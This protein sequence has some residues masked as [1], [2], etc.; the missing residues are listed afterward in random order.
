MYRETKA[1][2]AKINAAKNVAKKEYDK[3]AEQYKKDLAKV[4]ALSGSA[5]EKQT[6]KVR[7]MERTINEWRTAR[8]KE[9]QTEALKLRGEIVAE[10]TSAIND[11]MI[12]EPMA[13]V[14]DTGGM[15]LTGVPAIFTRRIPDL[16]DEIIAGLS[17]SGKKSQTAA[18]AAT[19]LASSSALRFGGVD[20]NRAFKAVPEGKQAESE[21]NALK[22]NAKA[23]LA[24]A[25]AAARKLKEDE[26]QSL[27]TKKREP[28][29][30]KIGESVRQL[31]ESGNFNVIFDTSGNSLN[32]VPLVISVHD[33]P[34]LTDDVIARASR[35]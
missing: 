10:I 13:V 17:K 2:E 1:S 14:L 19:P 7:E 9:L 18:S 3:K 20:I 5:K 11:R 24:N 34:D 30:K 22:E 33:L 6:A 16:S 8:E 31:A 29:I 15:T 12:S 32:G 25:D 21:I 26:I 4:N 28:I 35:P 27:A 23:E